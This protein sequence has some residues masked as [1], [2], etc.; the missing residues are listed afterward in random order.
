MKG[1]QVATPLDSACAAESPHTTAVVAGAIYLGC[2][3]R[4]LLTPHSHE[5]PQDAQERSPYTRQ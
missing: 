3:A 5:K 2:T 1:L 4:Y